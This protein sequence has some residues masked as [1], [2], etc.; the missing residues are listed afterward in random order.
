MVQSA[1][2]LLHFTMTL[3]QNE[4]SFSCLSDSLPLIN[5]STVMWTSDTFTDKMWD[6]LATFF[7][8]VCSND[9]SAPADCTVN[10]LLII[11]FSR[12]SL[13]YSDMYYG[14]TYLLSLVIGWCTEVWL[15]TILDTVKL[16][17]SINAYILRSC[18]KYSERKSRKYLVKWCRSLA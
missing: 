1:A 8:V 12:Y 10:T 4:E 2:E 9:V 5:L 18:Y 14:N 13:I 11:T 7:A 16:I 17:I 6:N 15:Q 3:T